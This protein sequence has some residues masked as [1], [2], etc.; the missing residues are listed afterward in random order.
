M[1]NWRKY[2]DAYRAWVLAQQ[3][4]GKTSMEAR[5]AQN[6]AIRIRAE[7]YGEYAKKA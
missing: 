7:V 5:N 4:H 6:E 3:T 1:F 2:D